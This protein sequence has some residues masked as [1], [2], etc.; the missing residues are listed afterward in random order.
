M[1]RENF[2]FVSRSGYSSDLAWRIGREEH[3]VRMFI[4]EDGQRDVADGFVDKTTDWRQDVDWADVVVFDDT[5]GHGAWATELRAQG[6]AVVGGTAWTDRLEDD[7]AFG[8]DELR[9]AGVKTTPS[10]D[11]DYFEDAVRHVQDYP[12]RYVLKLSSEAKLSKSLVFVGEDPEGKDLLAALVRY[13]KRLHEL[14]PLRLQLQLRIEGVEVGVG[15]F[16]NGREFVAPLQ[17]IFEHKR[18]LAGDLGPLTGGMGIALHWSPPTPLF[19][20]TLGRMTA[21]LAAA[22][23]RGFLSLNCIANAD[24]I[25][26]LEFTTRFGYPTLCAQLEAFE[27][28]FPVG[29]FFA[30]LARGEAAELKIGSRY[31]VGVRAVAPPYPAHDPEKFDLLSRDMAVGLLPNAPG[32]HIEDLKKVDGQ[33]RMAGSSGVALTVAGGGDTPQQARKQAYEVLRNVRFPNIGYRVDI[34]ERWPEDLDLLRQ[35]GYLGSPVD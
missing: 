8:Q 35:W 2:L 5:L 10:W 22:G 34:A 23:Y 7:R 4:Q 27:D 31:Q 6:K 1:R 32:L 17:L 33:W 12:G 30:D 20:R 26:P 11:F 14:K 3:D 16:F 21:Q 9:K 19:E 25:F 24:D 18:H 13:Q 28:R 29:G 15:G